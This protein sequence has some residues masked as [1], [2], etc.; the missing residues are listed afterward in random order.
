MPAISLLGIVLF[1]L[2]AGVGY[3]LSRSLASSSNGSRM[4]IGVLVTGVGVASLFEFGMIL[5]LAL[6]FV[7]ILI[8][9]LLSHQFN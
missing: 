2:Q 6:D 8:S 9:T 1:V 3:H 4:L 7:L 5:T